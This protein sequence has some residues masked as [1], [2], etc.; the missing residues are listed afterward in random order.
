VLGFHPQQGAVE[1]MD[2]C[3]AQPGQGDSADRLLAVEAAR[4]ETGR[5]S[6]RIVP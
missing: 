2:A 1:Q 6:G 5:A 4:R 3:A